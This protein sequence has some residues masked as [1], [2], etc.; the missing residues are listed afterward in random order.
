MTEPQ[1]LDVKVIYD[2]SSGRR[3]APTRSVR[4]VRAK[5]GTLAIFLGCASVVV[6]GLLYYGTWW[7]VDQQIY[8]KLMMHMP[9]PGLDVSEVSRMFGLN[10]DEVARSSPTLSERPEAGVS[11]R[12]VQVMLGFA[13]YGWLVVATLSACGV[14]MAGAAAIAR[15]CDFDSRRI[16]IILCG[17]V[18]LGLAWGIASTWADF[19][20]DYK[21]NH[22]RF[23]MLAPV[24]FAA[25]LGLVFSSGARM[26]SR[27]AGITLIAA[28]AGSVAALW[29]GHRCDAVDAAYVSLP[30]LALVFAGHSFW[31]WVLWVLGGRWIR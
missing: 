8:L 9:V 23:G 7:K 5:G 30:V 22:L 13:C 21:P 3:S 14:A 10:A 15:A 19:G 24:A 18:F 29:L 26:L 2:A 12:T 20:W 16:G 17:G 6:S 1:S 27:V 28:A 25:S 11:T 31:G 4:P